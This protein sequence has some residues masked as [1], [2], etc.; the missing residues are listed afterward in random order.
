MNEALN[1]LHTKG[2]ELSKT[3]IQGALLAILLH[4]IGHGPFSHTLEK[5]I[6]SN[7]EHEDVSM[8]FMKKF[9]TLF[10]GKLETGIKIF[11]NSHPKKFLHQLV[12]SQLDM[13]RLDY[14]T[15]DSFFTG[16]SE[17]I[18]GTERIIKMLDV[19]N[20][21]LVAESK[22]IYSLEKFIVSRRLMYWQ[23]YLHK[24]V[25]AAE[26]MLL[27]VLKRAKYL[28]QNGEKLFASPAL[29][30]FLYNSITGNDIISD[31]E[32]LENYAKLDDFDILSAIKVW[33]G[34]KDIVLSE[35]CNGII[36]RKLFKCE[37]QSKPFEYFY[38][39]DIKT[40]V[41]KKYQIS[42]EELDYFFYND[43]TSNHAYNIKTKNIN[44]LFKSGKVTDI[45]EASDQLNISVM[46]KPVTKHF[47]CYPKG[48]E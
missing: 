33:C 18:I 3:E 30:F 20:G 22:G 14:L 36:N 24:T 48:I 39:E 29:E 47:I 25:L 1:I 9:N 43:T 45:V 34:S 26:Y 44:I 31:P 12:S 2:I 11:S 21:N 16:V 46:S 32:V 7:I 10:P 40:K 15:R 6:I 8:L 35:I 41:Q 19:N 28:A 4:D 38:I 42:T 37:I 17:G 13:D 5:S 27:N 23:V